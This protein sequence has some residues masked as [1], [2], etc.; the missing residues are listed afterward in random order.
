[1]SVQVIRASTTVNDLVEKGPVA[2]LS[3]PPCRVSGLEVAVP[4]RPSCKTGIW[5]CT[6][7]RFNRQIAAGEVM[8]ILSGSG[9]FKTEEGSTFAFQAGDTLVFPPDTRGIWTIHDT[10][11]KV[12]VL[13]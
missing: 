8:H 7:G 1:M 9:E 4:Q 10:V 6:P 13:V 2:S 12:Y 11:R 5:E 3:E